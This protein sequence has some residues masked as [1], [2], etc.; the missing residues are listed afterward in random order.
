MASG[1]AKFF[2]R[3]LKF[4]HME[5]DSALQQLAWA[6]VSP[7]KLYRHH[8]AQY[9][10]RESW[11]RDDPAF[12]VCICGFLLA[13]TLG[14]TIF[15]RLGVIGFFLTVLWTVLVDCIVTGLIVASL[16]WLLTN[17]F[18]MKPNSREKVQW[19]YCFDVHLNSF[20]PLALLVFVLQMPLIG[21]L[22]HRTLLWTI[23]ANIMW[24]CALSSYIYSTFLGYSVMSQLRNTVILLFPVL[25]FLTVGVASIPLK[26]NYSTI[27][28]A[29]L[30]SR[31]GQ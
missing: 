17:N 28:A 7:K 4:Q 21:V 23:V 25:L 19:S 16:L 2:T 1:K 9:K 27:F 20:V 3:L 15:L 26:W 18:L 10:T 24:V 30:R 8:E 31:I 13:S 22:Q 12:L 6:I 29:Y 14:Y 11:S 5:F